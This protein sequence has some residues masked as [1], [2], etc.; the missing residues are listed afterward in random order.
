MGFWNGGIP[1]FDCLILGDIIL[2]VHLRFESIHVLRVIHDCWVVS[3]WKLKQNWA[4]R[5]RSDTQF[6]CFFLQFVKMLFKCRQF[7]V[8]VFISVDSFS[9]CARAH[10]VKIITV[11]PGRYDK[12]V[13]IYAF[14]YGIAVGST[15][16]VA[17]KSDSKLLF[18][19]R[20]FSE[21][22]IR[23]RKKCRFC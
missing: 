16:G 23:S 7:H 17:L 2:Y 4:N 6:F 9:C 11:R 18:I 1:N 10:V 22:V 5:A 15:D 20:L 8:T 3:Q 19:L 12:M 13:L 14:K 21:I